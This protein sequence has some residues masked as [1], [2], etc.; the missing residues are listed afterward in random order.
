MDTTNFLNMRFSNT[1]R[2]RRTPERK[3]TYQTLNKGF[4]HTLQEISEQNWRIQLKTTEIEFMDQLEINY[5]SRKKKVGDQ[6]EPPLN[7]QRKT[8]SLLITPGEKGETIQ[9]LSQT[10]TMINPF[11]KFGREILSYKTNCAT[12]HISSLLR[13][14][15]KIWTS[16]IWQ[17]CSIPSDNR[18]QLRGPNL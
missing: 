6:T 10:K 2:S 14:W 8:L 1:Y 16:M 13:L 12:N 9:T 4:M 17:I 15:F 3:R 18:T 7:T 11:Q 5:G